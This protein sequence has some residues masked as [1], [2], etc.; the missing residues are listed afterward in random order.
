[1]CFQGATTKAQTI[2]SPTFLTN[3]AILFAANVY[4]TSFVT[5]STSGNIYFYVSGATA[6]MTQYAGSGG[7]NTSDSRIKD[8]IKDITPQSLNNFLKLKTKEF[9]IRKEKYD[10]FTISKII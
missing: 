10:I 7:W 9:K 3:S 4:S 5:N 1:L 8:N 2:A 6:Y